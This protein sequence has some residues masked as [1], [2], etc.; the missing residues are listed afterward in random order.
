MTGPLGGPSPRNRLCG[1][2]AALHTRDWQQPEAQAGREPA[3]GPQPAVLLDLLTLRSLLTHHTDPS[4]DQAAPGAETTLRCRAA[5]LTLTPGL[6]ASRG[7]PLPGS[8]HPQRVAEQRAGRPRRSGIGV[9]S[10]VLTTGDDGQ[11]P[12]THSS[13]ESARSPAC[14]PTARGFLGDHWRPTQP[15][16]GSPGA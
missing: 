10:T 11:Q 8:E 6:S 1:Q 4:S 2:A 5:K 12:P 13:P 15:G 3:Q 16:L 9:V 14:L 7:Q